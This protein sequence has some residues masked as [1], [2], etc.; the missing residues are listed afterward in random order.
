MLILLNLNSPREDV[1]AIKRKVLN[2]NCQPHEIPGETN[3]AIGITGPTHQMSE[4]EF[5]FMN[6]V[7]DVVRVSKKYKLVNRQMKQSDTIV[8]TKFGNIGGKELTIIAGP[9][10]VEGRDQIF[11]TA[12]DVA[13]LGI[14]FLRG[15]AYKPRSSPYSFRGLKE[16]GLK[17]LGEVKKEFGIGIVTEV[18]SSDTIPLVKEVADIIQIGARNMQNFTLLDDVGKTFVPILLKRGLSATVEDLLL[19]AE[20][21]L[22]QGNFNVI[23][24]ERGIRTF[25]TSTRNTLDLNAVPVIKQESHLPIIVDPSHGIGIRDKV[26]PMALAGIAAG[27]DGIMVEVHHDPDS[28]LSDGTQTISPAQMQVLLKKIKAMAPIFEKELN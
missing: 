20:Y 28:A 22:A 18:L 21:I 9:C 11:K 19:S 2:K 15:G 17:L 13:K 16:E 6:S 12:E 5:R 24:C 1:E 25:E 27:A 26:S 7:V 4:D 10:S 23:L 3:L 14:K 8:E